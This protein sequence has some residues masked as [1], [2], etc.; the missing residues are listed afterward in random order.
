MCLL[1]LITLGVWHDNFNIFAIAFHI[2]GCENIFTTV[3]SPMCADKWILIYP[4]TYNVFKNK[5]L[6]GVQVKNHANITRARNLKKII[7]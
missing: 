2:F 7:D 4:Y 3:K 6:E 5:I 1:L